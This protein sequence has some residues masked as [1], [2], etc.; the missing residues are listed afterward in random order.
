MES[1]KFSLNE[2]EISKV[3]KVALYAGGSAFIA[4]LITLLPQINISAQWIWVV[5]IVNVVL[6][7]IK[8]FFDG[9]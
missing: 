2:E 9:K 8:K 7:A 4:S 3:L 6:V 5:P 1:K